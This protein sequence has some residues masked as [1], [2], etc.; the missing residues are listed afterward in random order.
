MIS[1][2]NR[3][4]LLYP[5]KG[6][7]V[8]CQESEKIFRSESPLNFNQSKNK[9]YLYK[10]KKEI[11]PYCDSHESFLSRHRDRDYIINLIIKNM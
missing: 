5:S 8:L 2:K 1:I 7:E 10:Y 3:G 9:Q 4:G 6:V 11:I